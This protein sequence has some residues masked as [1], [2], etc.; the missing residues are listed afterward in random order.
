[1]ANTSKI[2]QS[3]HLPAEASPS[4]EAIERSVFEALD[5]YIEVLGKFGITVRRDTPE[6]RARLRALPASA[7]QAL[8][9]SFTLKSQWLN[10]EL[11]YEPV[12][13]GRPLGVP[14]ERRLV[15]RVLRHFGLEVDE[16][17]WATV[18]EGD[19]IEVYGR[20][21][22][23]LYRNLEFFRICGYS[24]LEVSTIEWFDLWE[25]PTSILKEM[26]RMAES[27]FEE[28]V[29]VR[30]YNVP[31]HILR[32][33]RSANPQLGYEPRANLV[34][35]KVMAPIRVKGQ[36]KGVGAIVTSRGEPIITGAD[37]GRIAFL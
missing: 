35:F 17:F 26:M 8:T 15:E 7:Q 18:T 2:V 9:D 10:E 5:S 22:V 30:S 24:I 19:L 14:R 23:Q 11:T 32:E 20:N 16:S 1:M 6:S 13:K 12:E 21:M 37:S 34:D 27:A 4:M 29:P 28:N 25:R 36:S 33:T 31:R 3:S